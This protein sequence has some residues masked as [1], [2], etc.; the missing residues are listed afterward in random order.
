[1]HGYPGHLSR[2]WTPPSGESLRVRPIRHD[3]GEREQAFVFA[4]SLESRHQRMLSAGVKVT[5]EW[6]DSMTHIDYY[7][8]MAFAVTTL[9]HG[10]KQFV[11]VGRYVLDA[12][13]LSAEVALELADAWQ[14]QGLGRRLL[15]DAAR[16][17]ADHRGTRRGR[18]CSCHERG[19]AA[20]CPFHGL[21]RDRGAGRCHG[22]A[23]QGICES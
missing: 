2:T 21:R 16:A 3:D 14:G 6:I 15:G 5:P 10:D 9:S 12:A 7:R 17:R 20:T 4:L 8:H 13:T 11:G 22:R 18:R 19:H 23:H 1:M